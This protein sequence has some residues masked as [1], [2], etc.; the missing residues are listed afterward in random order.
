MAGSWDFAKQG[1]GVDAFSASQ[2]CGTFRLRRIGGPG[3]LI[4]CEGGHGP[5]TTVESIINNYPFILGSDIVEKSLPKDA[6][7]HHS[8][9]VVFE[10]AKCGT[11][12]RD[13]AGGADKEPA[14]SQ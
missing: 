2:E 14:V 11:G 4:L 7:G 5:H 10:T 13:Q 8:R 3:A 6:M 9:L 12:F 1:D